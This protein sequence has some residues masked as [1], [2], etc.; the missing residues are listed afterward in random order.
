M[1]AHTACFRSE[2][3]LCGRDT[4]GMIR[5][6]QFDKVEM[7]Q[8]SASAGLRRRAG[9]ID[10]PCGTISSSLLNL[11]YRVLACVPAIWVLERPALRSGSLDSDQGKV[12][13]SRASSCGDFR[14][15]RIAARWRNP[16]NRQAGAG[17]YP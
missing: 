8:I 4:R 2:A 5:Q 15:R 12:V 14:R 6:H 13:N 10:R 3:G 11:P 16:G 1:T 7:V 17:A 9:A